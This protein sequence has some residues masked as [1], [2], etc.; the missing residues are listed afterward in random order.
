MDKC[1]Q[2]L[3]ENP[4]AFA[5]QTDWE[6]ICVLRTNM[7]MEAM[8]R[9]LWLS[10]KKG[11]GAWCGPALVFKRV[12]LADEMRAMKK[13]KNLHNDLGRVETIRDQTRN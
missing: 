10:I 7:T 2:M 9:L 5:F 3:D 6:C 12:F 1:A 11:R 13:K 4:G 8:G